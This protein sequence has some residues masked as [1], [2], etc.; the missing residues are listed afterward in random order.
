MRLIPFVRQA[1]LVAPSTVKEIDV[2]S[3]HHASHL[4]GFHQIRGI[5]E[6][7]R[8]PGV[9]RLEKEDDL[10]GVAR[11]VPLLEPRL[12]ALGDMGVVRSSTSCSP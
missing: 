4:H 7:L 8:A 10:V 6:G 1:I 12:G 3:I 5:G 2:W 11:K 9:R